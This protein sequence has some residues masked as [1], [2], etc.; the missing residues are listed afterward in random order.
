MRS[1]EISVCFLIR[2]APELGLGLG[3]G[4]G[5]VSDS[6]LGLGL[7]ERKRLLFETAVG[8][9]QK[10]RVDN[11][12]PPR[13]Q[14]CNDKSHVSTRDLLSSRQGYIS[15]LSDNLLSCKIEKEYSSHAT[16]MKFIA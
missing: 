11:D 4:L 15:S 5:S 2:E 8:K 10:F 9:Y 16:A 13:Q 6:G 12:T 14:R 7:G 3:L 1:Q